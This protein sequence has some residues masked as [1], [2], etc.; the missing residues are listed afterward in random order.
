MDNVNDDEVKTGDKCV[1]LVI[2]QSRMDYSNYFI[3]SIRKLRVYSNQTIHIGV[4]IIILLELV[5]VLFTVL[6]LEDV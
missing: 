3:C 1:F 2:F 5:K 6:F 4:I